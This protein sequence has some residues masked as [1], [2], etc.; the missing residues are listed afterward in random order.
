MKYPATHEQLK[1]EGFIFT[2][3]AACTGP[4]CRSRV[5]WFKTPGGAKIP[6][7]RVITIPETTA[8]KLFATA[9]VAPCGPKYQPH[10]ADCPDEKMFRKNN[11]AKKANA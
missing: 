1:A 7:S 2:N 10:F 5:F 11:A 9:P 4:H 6:M 8:G 3:D